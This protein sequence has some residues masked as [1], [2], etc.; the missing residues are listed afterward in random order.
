MLGG[1][2]QVEIIPMDVSINDQSYCYGPQGNLTVSSFY[3]LQREGHFATTTQINPQVYR[4]HFEE[5]LKRGY[6]VLY[7]CFSSGMSGTINAARMCMEELQKEY[8]QRKLICMDTLCAS[9]G[10][11]FLVHEAARKQAEGMSLFELADW[12]ETYRLKVCHWFTVDTF[13]HLK[14]GG[15]VSAAAAAVGGVLNIKPLL[16]VDEVGLL[17]VAQKPRGQRL[18]IR[19]QLK[20]MEEGWQPEISNLVVVAGADNPSGMTILSDAIAERFPEANILHADIG[21]II[22][23]HTGPGMLAVIYWGSNR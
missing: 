18:A 13:T 19:A 20:C 1:V 3:R 8:P 9:V 7:L 12:I 21:P 16:H 14:H 11:G 6:D 15:R 5:I 23:A 17:K 4:K 22:G 2:P 10:E